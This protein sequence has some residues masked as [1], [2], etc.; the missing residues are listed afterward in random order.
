MSAPKASMTRTCFNHRLLTN[1]QLA[2][3]GGSGASFE[4]LPAP[5]YIYPMKM[6]Y[7]GLS[8]TK[9]F[10]FHGIFKEIVR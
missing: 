1:I 4:P 5:V 7:I 6:K 3:S 8:E 9:L 2:N 10:P